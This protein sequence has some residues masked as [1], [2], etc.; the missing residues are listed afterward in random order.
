MSSLGFQNRPL[1]TVVIDLAGATEDQT[2]VKFLDEA[3]GSKLSSGLFLRISN[4]S[5]LFLHHTCRLLLELDLEINLCLFSS[6]QLAVDRL[7]HVYKVGEVTQFKEF[8]RALS[9][10]VVS[11][12]IIVHYLNM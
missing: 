4:A 7:F 3:I 9:N 10:T 12:N 1:Y 8:D 5:F 11:S 6:K 2:K